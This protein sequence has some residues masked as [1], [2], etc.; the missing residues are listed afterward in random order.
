MA[1]IFLN[2]D[3]QLQYNPAT[4]ITPRF[5]I[6]G[7]RG[8]ITL[9][10][11]PSGCGKTTCL[12]LLAGLVRPAAGYIK[13][14]S[15]KWNDVDEGIHLSPQKRNIG[16]LFQSYALFPHLT[17]RQ[18]IAYALHRLSK[19]DRDQRV[20]E[21]AGMLE[22]ATLLDQ[23]PRTLSGGQAQRVAL[24]RA[25]AAKPKWLFL[26]EPLSAL[27]E[28][29]RF[30]IGHELREQIKRIG[31]PTVMVTHDRREIELLGDDLVVL[32]K[33]KVL[34]HGP[35]N[36]LMHG[37]KTLATARTLGF[38]NIFEITGIEETGMRVKGTDGTVFLMT[39]MVGP[40]AGAP[41]H[42][43]IRSERI[44]ISSND[45]LPSATTIST[46]LE[47]KT[48]YGPLIKLGFSS[49]L[50]LKV[51]LTRGHPLSEALVVGDTF[52]IAIPTDAICFLD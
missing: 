16:Y 26:D 35:V 33:G 11:G 6:N 50:A 5:Q 2:L 42:L 32:E 21:L 19:A 38:E 44:G 40:T 12:R 45:E 29:L 4:V 39:P 43:G 24:A 34:E 9:L 46:R 28:P 30:R 51:S 41:T 1:E 25:L 22:I 14:E 7:D 23:L 20:H 3:C 48:P 10:F 27:D 52:N 18:N 8:R 31:I 49:P 36:E 47:S 13:T 37:P 15:I 17:V